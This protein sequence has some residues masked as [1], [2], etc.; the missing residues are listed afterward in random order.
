VNTAK[1]N[2]CVVEGP[3]HCETAVG[4]H[5]DISP[6]GYNLHGVLGCDQA[7]VLHRR[8]ALGLDGSETRPYNVLLRPPLCLQLRQ[9]LLDP[10]FL[11][12][13]R[14]SVLDVFR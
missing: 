3:L 7:L 12:Q 1:R 14:Q 2:S 5:Q 13:R 8:A 9:Q 11:L 4:S 10:I 6:T